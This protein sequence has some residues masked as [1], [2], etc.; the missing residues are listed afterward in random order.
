MGKC[1]YQ[2]CNLGCQTKAQHQSKYATMRNNSMNIQKN[3]KSSRIN[4][5][6]LRNILQTGE[7]LNLKAKTKV[8]KHE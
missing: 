2:N 6:V 3:K 4:Y 7:M 5:D 1:I 8:I